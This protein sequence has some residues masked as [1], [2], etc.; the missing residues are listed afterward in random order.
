MSIFF[1]F[2]L[3]LKAN[4]QRLPMPGNQAKRTFTPNKGQSH[5][6]NDPKKKKAQLVQTNW[7]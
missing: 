6:G 7:Q 5:L 1:S 2:P 3:N 4:G